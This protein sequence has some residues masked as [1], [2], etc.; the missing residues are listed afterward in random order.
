MTQAES[1][2]VRVLTLPDPAATD[3]LGGEL[4]AALAANQRAVVHLQGDLGS[5]KTSLA[6]ALLRALGVKGP[7]RSPTY[8]LIERYALAGGGECAHL[9]LY[10]IA[11]PEELD[12]L[13]LDELATAARIWLVEWPQRG[14]ARLPPADL[15]VELSVHLDGRAA[16]L[17]AATAT[18]KEW[19]ARLLFRD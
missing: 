10:R 17:D 6:R 14:I 13:A 11:D 16:R 18:G 15:V 5:G 1:G 4:A 8:T 9:D 3:R 7:I 19:I 12:Y 2:G